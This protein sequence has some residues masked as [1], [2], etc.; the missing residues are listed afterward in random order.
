MLINISG[1]SGVGKT[2]ISTIIS[3]VLTNLKS[4]VLHLCGDDLHKWERGDDNWKTITHLNPKANN[5]KLGEEQITSLLMGKTI[6]RDHYDHNTGKFI[7]DLE[8]TPQEILINEGLHSLYSKNIC[9]KGK[10]NIFV[11]TEDELKYQWKLN[12]AY[13]S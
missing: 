5:L 6:K 7:K 11:E 10:L 12:R 3:L 2:T 9:K 4:R 13:R 8:I 1:S